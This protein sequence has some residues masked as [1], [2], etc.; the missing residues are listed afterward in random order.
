MA[1]GYLSSFHAGYP[2]RK[3]RRDEIPVISFEETRGSITTEHFDGSMI[4][5]GAC[6]FP[7]VTIKNMPPAAYPEHI[8]YLTRATVAAASSDSAGV[9]DMMHDRFVQ[10]LAAMVVAV[11][12]GTWA[13]IGYVPQGAVH[14]ASDCTVYQTDRS[15]AIRKPLAQAQHMGSW[16][17]CFDRARQ[18]GRTMLELAHWIAHLAP[19]LLG[20]QCMAT[21]TSVESF[22]IPYIQQAVTRHLKGKLSR[23][24]VAVANL[25]KPVVWDALLGAS[26]HG[27]P[28]PVAM[29]WA[30]DVLFQVQAQRRMMS[31]SAELAASRRQEEAVKANV[32]RTGIDFETASVV[33]ID[34]SFGTAVRAAH[35]QAREDDIGSVVDDYDWNDPTEH[36]MMWEH[37]ASLASADCSPPPAMTPEDANV[38]RHAV[39]D[40][41]SIGPRAESELID[42]NDNQEVVW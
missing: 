25:G 28:K 35:A 14:A 11:R 7:I 37:P 38:I 6:I 33:G 2:A 41:A 9:A 4:T 8:G 27:L 40:A 20:M 22:S 29:A 32:A 34:T 36:D 13:S 10:Q 12:C 42:T 30:T 39:R 1:A 3:V 21:A 16:Y 31:T 17:V 15:R 23:E 19:V 24:A 26:T 5:T 18:V